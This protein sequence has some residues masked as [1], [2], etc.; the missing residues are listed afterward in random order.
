MDKYN[1]EIFMSRLKK[2]RKEKRLNQPQLG[3]MIGKTKAAIGHYEAETREPSLETLYFFSKYFNVSIDYLLGTTDFRNAS[4]AIDYMFDKLQEV[5]LIK[6]E[7]IDKET[8][9][10]LIEYITLIMKIR[11]EKK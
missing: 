1:K 3:E 2:L 8:M 4:D 10:T 5:G 11:T 7:Q 6:N 9:D